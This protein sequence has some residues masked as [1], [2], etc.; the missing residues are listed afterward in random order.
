MVYNIRDRPGII[1]ALYFFKNERE[2]N[3]VQQYS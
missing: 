3:Y 2:Y 1:I